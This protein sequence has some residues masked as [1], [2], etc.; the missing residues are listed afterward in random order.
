MEDVIKYLI[1]H[2][3]NESRKL[4]NV[5]IST[6]IYSLLVLLHSQL[7]WRRQLVTLRQNAL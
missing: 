3:D 5:L 1:Q 2:S 4:K 6:I 7:C